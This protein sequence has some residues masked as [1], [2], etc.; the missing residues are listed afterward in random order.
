MEAELKLEPRQR[1]HATFEPVNT[2]T[3]REGAEKF[4]GHYGEW[5]AGWVL[6]DGDYEGDWAMI[7]TYDNPFEFGWVPLCD[8]KVDE[9][10]EGRG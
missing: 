6:E 8:L 2:S 4:I 10:M 3:L 7:P 1:I 5:Y 9:L